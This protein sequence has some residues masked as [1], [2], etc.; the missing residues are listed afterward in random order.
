VRGDKAPLTVKHVT[1]CVCD[2]YGLSASF[3][4]KEPPI[5]MRKEAGWNLE[6]GGCIGEEKCI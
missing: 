3:L 4:G 2:L 6:F 1:R 5:N